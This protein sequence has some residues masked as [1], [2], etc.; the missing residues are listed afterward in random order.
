MQMDL[1]FGLMF[2]RT[3]MALLF[4]LMLIYISMKY[5]GSKLQNIQNRRY[6]KILERVSISK[7]NSL[8]VVKIGQK[9]YVMA[10]TNG[11]VEIISELSQEEIIEVVTLNAIPQ[12]KDL[13]DFYEKTGLKKIS[14][15][16]PVKNFYEKLRFK[17]EDRNE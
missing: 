2:L 17:K 7:E 15:K 12:Y 3:I 6:I 11:K 13:K 8:L 14:E 4:I 5:G 9:A 1:Q 10:S 16:V